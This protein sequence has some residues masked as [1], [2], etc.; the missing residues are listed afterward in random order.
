MKPVQSF[1]DDARE[2]ALKSYN[3]N[4]LVYLCIKFLKNYGP[5]SD[6]NVF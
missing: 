5:L 4:N 2:K 3:D 6:S 1:K